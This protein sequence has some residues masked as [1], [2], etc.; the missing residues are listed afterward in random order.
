MYMK[1][2]NIKWK[3]NDICVTQL[4]GEDV[5]KKVISQLGQSIS[6]FG[7]LSPHSSFYRMVK[8]IGRLMNM[9][10]INHNTI[11]EPNSD[12]LRFND[13]DILHIT[14]HVKFMSALREGTTGN[15][16][17]LRI[18]GVKKMEGV[19]RYLD[20]IEKIRAMLFSLV[21][22]KTYGSEND[23]IILLSSVLHDV[24]K[25]RGSYLHH[26]N[27]ADLVDTYVFD[28]L[29]K[30][31]DVLSNR[32]RDIVRFYIRHHLAF[33]SWMMTFKYIDQQPP[34]RIK[35]NSRWM[36]MFLSEL[37][38]LPEPLKY[39]YLSSNEGKAF[40]KNE[41]YLFF[42]TLSL[43]NIPGEISSKYVARNGSI[44]Q[45]HSPLLTQVEGIYDVFSY[46]DKETVR[47]QIEMIDE[48]NSDNS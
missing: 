5:R 8:D 16:E 27:G 26:I 32:V 46:E 20:V 3:E 36:K 42:L 2:M 39:P 24:G 25:C 34:E 48:M 47:R 40:M 31:S 14:S 1:K 44:V 37:N 18:N 35:N 7:Y 41:G 33:G 29:S 12:Y 45:V 19:R 21:T 4:F 11:I 17:I 6:D 22:D 30:Y 23:L 43:I 10:F 15:K 13:K 38:Q 9:V 28:K